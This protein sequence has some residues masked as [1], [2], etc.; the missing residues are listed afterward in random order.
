MRRIGLA[1]APLAAALAGCPSFSTM[2]LARTVP[3]DTN[4]IYIAPTVVGTTVRTSSGGQYETLTLPQFEIGVR[5]GV[6]D[7][8]EIGG[9]I[10]LLGGAFDAK[11]Q[12]ARG[13]LD[14]AVDPAVSW[15]GFKSGSDGFNI[16]S[17][18]LPILFGVN[19]SPGTQ[20]V[21]TPKA[22]SQFYFAS[23]GS[24]SGSA[25]VLFT[26]GSVG[27]AFKLGETT[28]ILPEATVLYPVLNPGQSSSLSYDGVVFQAGV[29]I[30]FGG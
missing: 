5:R 28:W 21:L 18:Y 14:V 4:Q 25:N 7:G 2:G 16:V 11:F 17:V 26:G 29:G 15:I 1:V 12:L 8:V 10:W 24:S 23:G 19:L 3:K 27:L 9:K 6:T 30:L 20:L 22:I 13:G